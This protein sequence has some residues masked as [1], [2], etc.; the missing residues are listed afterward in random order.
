[1]KNQLNLNKC[2]ICGLS[3]IVGESYVCR[4][5]HD[6]M[7][8][9]GQIWLGDGT[10]YYPLKRLPKGYTHKINRNLTK[11]K[12]TDDYTAPHKINRN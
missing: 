11:R 4:T 3:F 5:F 10:K 9:D 2:E 6:F 7:I 1:M 8:I 12:S